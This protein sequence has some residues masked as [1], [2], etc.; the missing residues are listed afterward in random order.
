MAST[1]P[2]RTEQESLMPRFARPLRAIVLLHAALIL[3][4]AVLAGQFLSGHETWLRVHETNAGIIQLIGL[5]QLVVAV[6]VWR[7][8][9]GPGWPALT[10][11]ALLLA[12]EFQIGFGYARL[13]ALHVPLG[14]AIFGLTVALLVGTGRLTRTDVASQERPRAPART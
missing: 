3:T 10:S 5:V 4:Q 11:L 6:L 2:P 14:V 12:E 9:G 1:D 13:L 8:G 7:P